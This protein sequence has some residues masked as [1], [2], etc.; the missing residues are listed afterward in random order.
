MASSALVTSNPAAA[1]P[2]PALGSRAILTRVL[3]LRSNIAPVP[4]M[5]Q[6]GQCSQTGNRWVC[7]NPC[8]DTKSPGSPSWVWSGWA[9]DKY[10]LRAINRAHRLMGLAPMVLP[11][12]WE[13][14]SRP[15]QLLVVID[16]ERRAEHLAPYLGLNA[17]LSASALS[18]A[19]V[20][21]DPSP[22]PAFP[23]AVLGG[24]ARFGSVWSSGSNVLA[25]D[26]GWMYNDGWAGT[27]AN[28][29]NVGCT[30]AQSPRCWDHRE[31]LLGISAWSDVGVGLDCTTCE[32]G[33]AFVPG[34][35]GLLTA[36][37][38]R[39]SG[40]PPAMY[41]TWASESR[42]FHFASTHPTHGGPTT[43]STTSTTSTT[44][45]PITPTSTA[46]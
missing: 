16:L 3:N 11:S 13:H 31:E 17:L 39:P 1:A 33:A 8:L 30:S 43:T 35:P 36:L 6:S 12:N 7:P 45:A 42:F 4:N 20:N 9:C 32:V 2:P 44:V 27:V 34:T 40:R 24:M 19:R 22:V 15:E 41:F 46:P 21:A 29:S 26:Y 25:A 14:L 18:A 23:T 10:V 28:T 5:L 38:E 37:V